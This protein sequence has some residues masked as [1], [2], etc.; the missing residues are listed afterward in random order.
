MKFIAKYGIGIYLIISLLFKLYYIVPVSLLNILYY[1]LMALGILVF[2]IS[3]KQILKTKYIKSFG[4]LYLIVI[5]NF[6]YLILFNCNTESVLYFLAKFSTTN[7]IACGLIYNYQFYEKFIKQYLI[8]I[9]IFMLAIGYLSGVIVG[10]LSGSQRLSIGFNPNDIG[11]FS[12]L[13]ALSILIFNPKWY[14]N[15]KEFFLFFTFILLA[16]LSGSK[17]ALFITLVGI[18]LIYGFNL[19]LI[20]I[21]FLIILTF[22]FAPKLGYLTSIDRLT[23]NEG[24]FDSRDQVYVLGLLTLND[25]FYTGSG[26]DKYAWTDPKYWPNEESSMGPHNTYISIGIMYGV[27]FGSIFLII[28]LSFLFKAKRSWIKF[29]NPFIRFC[30]LIVFLTLVNGFSESLIVGVNEFITIL[31][32]FA[33]GALGYYN[34]NYKIC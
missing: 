21:S 33:V 28:L 26:I 25:A 1:V 16:L 12:A 27:I 24:L 19:K 29:K 7:L 15:K 18:I 23:S 14:K 17:T 2:F 30:A 8:Y 6:I 22:L 32:W 9:I 11:L 31:F 20:G 5:L 13:G 34:I 3:Y 4:L 10:D